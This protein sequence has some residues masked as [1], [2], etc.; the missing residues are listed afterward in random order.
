[1][2][3]SHKDIEGDVKKVLSHFALVDSKNVSLA[4]YYL[5]EKLTLDVH[6]VPLG[7]VNAEAM[8]ETANAVKQEVLKVPEVHNAN[9]YL[10]FSDKNKS[11]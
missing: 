11:V 1:L 6:L 5:D 4:Y 9:V 8:K 7:D 10:L 2:E 3:R